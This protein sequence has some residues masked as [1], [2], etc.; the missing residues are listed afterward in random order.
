MISRLLLIVLS[1]CFVQN[2]FAWGKRG[3]ETVASLAAQ[4]L[5]KENPQ[6]QFLLAHSYDMGFYANAPDLV[7]KADDETYKKEFSQHYIDMEAFERKFTE[8]KKANAWNPDR[9]KFFKTFP[10]IENK[11]GRSFWRIE[12]L[13][14]QLV[15]VTKKL[16]NK[17]LDANARRTLQAEW[18]LTAGV[19]G[20]YMGDL[21]QPLHVT[22]NHDGQLTDQKGIHHW[23]EESIVDD[24]YPSFTN[25]VYTR[26]QSRWAEFHKKHKKSS[27]F[28]LALELAKNSQ[29]A[30]PEVLALDKKLGRESASKV[31][32][33][34]REIITERLTLGVLYLAQLWS[35]DLGW[36]FD[37]NR[38]FTFD[39]KPTYIEP[40]PDKKP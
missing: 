20:H 26:A 38:F 17:K 5:A 10:E 15:D 14:T 4:L 9:Q 3:H 18:L 16:K 6:T 23:F 36:N 32:S 11:E 29:A 13:N 7:W 39:V 1:F 35:N 22:E 34:Y 40:T 31:S 30:L 12:E 27:A 28:D 2:A 24:L 8:R 33:A 21:A 25:D 19:I 37:D